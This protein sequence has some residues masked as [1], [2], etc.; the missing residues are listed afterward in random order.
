MRGGRQ[1]TGAASHV[2]FISPLPSSCFIRVKNW[3]LH[4]Q[5]DIINN[6]NKWTKL[7]YVDPFSEAGVGRCGGGVIR[8]LAEGET[9][10]PAR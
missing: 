1:K 7:Y 6:E 5:P 3:L 8:E 10:L 2:A 9:F 4:A